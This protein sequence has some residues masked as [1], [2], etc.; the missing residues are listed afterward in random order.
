MVAG[1]Q[2]WP[3]KNPRFSSEMITLLIALPLAIAVIGSWLRVQFFRNWFELPGHRADTFICRGNHHTVTV[4]VGADGFELPAD[5]GLIGRT[6]FLQVATKCS[7]LGRIFDPFIE[8]RAQELSFRQYFERG[9]SGSRYLNLT[10]FFQSDKQALRHIG[11]RG[12]SMRWAPV[13]TLIA[14]QPPF[15][16]G[17]SVLVIA[18]HADDA[19]IAAFGMCLDRRSWVV[20]ITA[21]EKSTGNLPQHVPPAARAEWAARLRLIDSLSN[22]QVGQVPAIWR[23][24]L[25]YPDGALESMYREPSRGFVL[26]CE[27]RLGRQELRSQNELREFRAG[28]PDC[29]WNGLVDELRLLLELTRPDIVICPHPLIDTHSDHIFATV[30]LEQAMRG[31]ERTR[32]QLLL[33]AVHNHGAPSYPF[34]PAESLVSLPPG[35]HDAWVGDSIY[36]LSLEPDMRLAKY[37]A[38]ESMHAV[39]R[40]EDAER[41]GA[42]NILKSM[43]REIVAYVAG[44]G[45]DPASW[46]RRAPR[47]NEI[48]Y[49]VSGSSL[50]ELIGRLERRCA[51]SA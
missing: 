19:E 33:Y 41:K 6:V 44:M 30:A 40:Y 34:G 4:H 31:L 18:P 38:V 47:P 7:L 8:M 17:A 10:P 51:T 23:L 14:Y 13:A 39:R 9:V 27:S 28:N 32:P 42:L 15:V 48:Y 5:L 29:T 22:R 35:Q 3:G 43:R 16:S 50:T 11:M 1:T 36:S 49:V 21:G 45:V 24:N 46:L 25:A 2:A 37:F 12:S 20:T 26:A